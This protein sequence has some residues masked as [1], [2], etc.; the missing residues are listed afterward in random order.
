MCNWLRRAGPAWTCPRGQD[1]YTWHL[2]SLITSGGLHLDAVQC[3]ASQILCVASDLSERT[4]H[5]G[6]DHGESG[7]SIRP[8]AACG[9][10]R[11]QQHTPVLIQPL[12]VIEALRGFSRLCSEL[13]LAAIAWKLA[14]NIKVYIQQG[15]PQ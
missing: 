4:Y 12:Y 6:H 5:R 2:P 7:H 10:Q 9:P 13:K 11:L 8:T 15:E 14:F 3:E 1:M